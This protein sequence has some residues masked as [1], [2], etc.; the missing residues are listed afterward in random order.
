MKIKESAGLVIL[1]EGK[2]L[3]IHPTGSKW[4]GSYGIPKGGIDKGETPLSAAI[5]EVREE[6]GVSVPINLIDKDM[7]SFM[8]KTSSY[9]KIVYYFIVRISNIS[10]IGL[11]ELRVPKSQLQLDEVDWAGF[12]TYEDAKKRVTK[13]QRDLIDNL[14]EHGLLEST[15]INNKKITKMNN[16]KGF[17]SFMNEARPGYKPEIGSTAH[18]KV[19]ADLRADLEKMINKYEDKLA[20]TELDQLSDFIVL[21]N[22][23]IKGK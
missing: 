1:Y 21:I 17:E 6:I 3:L 9:K 22:N 15:L 4:F 19:L 12:V 7:K 13:S 8:F 20:D 23:K 2:I 16:I 18:K 14:A 10:Q 5:R 11:S